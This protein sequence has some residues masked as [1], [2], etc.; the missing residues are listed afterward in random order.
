[1]ASGPGAEGRCAR[2][3]LHHRRGLGLALR[4]GFSGKE[5]MEALRRKES[6]SRGGRSREACRRTGGPRH[7][8]EWKTSVGKESHTDYKRHMRRGPP[9]TVGA[10]NGNV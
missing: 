1:M 4:W 7:K 2:W 3:K 10:H 6:R 5:E 9:S 8:E